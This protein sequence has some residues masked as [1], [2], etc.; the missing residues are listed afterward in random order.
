MIDLHLKKLRRRDDIG[1]QEEKFIRGLVSRTV[2][3]P[4]DKVIIRAGDALHESLMLF[5]GWMARAKD[6]PSGQR[7]Y[8]ELH[9]PGDF[10][11][12]HSYSLKRLDHDVISFTPCVVGVVPHERLDEMTQKFPHLTRIYWFQ[13]NLD[14]AIHRE[15]TLSMG[16]RTA[17]ARM[18]HLFCELLIRLDIVGMTTGRLSYDFPLTQIEL[19]ECLGLTGVHVNRTLQDLRRQGLIQLES[20]RVEILDLDGLKAV[21]EFDDTYLY[22]EKMKH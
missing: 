14:A 21:A 8:A 11:D 9:V 13:T 19:G 16:R 2:M 4:A 1:P 6:L 3:L 5:S 18:A 10:A 15:W 7:Q 20:R 12:L 17:V 22:L